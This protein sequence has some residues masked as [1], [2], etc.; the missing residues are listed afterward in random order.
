MIPGSSNLWFVN[1]LLLDISYWLVIWN[2]Q[3]NKYKFESKL[4]LES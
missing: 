2:D 4:D 1:K 3:N